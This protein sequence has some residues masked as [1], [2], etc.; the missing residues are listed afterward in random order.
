[1]TATK[2]IYCIGDSHINFFSGKNQIQASWPSPS[3]SYFPFFVPFRVGPVLAYSL[4]QLNTTNQGREKVFRILKSIPANSYVLFSFG[5][6]DCRNHLIKQAKV[7]KK[8]INSLVVNCVDRYLDMLNEVKALG[9]KILVWNVLP[10]CR[11]ISSENSP[12]PT[13][14]TQADRDRAIYLFN[15]ELKKGCKRRNFKF[16]SIY[17]K[18]TTSQKKAKKSYY[19]DEIHLSQKAM[20][21]TLNRLTSMIPDIDFSKRKSRSRKRLDTW[22]FKIKLWVYSLKM[23]FYVKFFGVKE[24]WWKFFLI[25]IGLSRFFW[26]HEAIGKVKEWRKN[27][28]PL[29]APAYFNQMLVREYQKKYECEVL[30]ET[31][32]FEGSMIMAV[33]ELFEKVYTIE[34]SDYYYKKSKNRLSVWKHVEVIKGDSARVLPKILTK[35]KGKKLLFWLDGHFSGG[36]T[37]KAKKDSPVVEELKVIA[38]MASRNCVVLVDD[39]REFT[40]KNGYP[41]LERLKKFLK[42]S[43]ENHRIT[44]E[45][46]VIRVTPKL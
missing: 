40:G 24:Y 14:G 10:L 41:K 34:L 17:D 5:E 45:D 23:F 11:Q 32:T 39:A 30:V 38:R 28:S 7:Q 18:V 33:A 21:L 42:G 2:K 19:F 6:I 36:K 8:T 43:L 26:W 4:S 16:V 12:Y 37:A 35:T 3:L 1:M 27:G 15:R 25:R 46:D 22:I 20:P 44:V 31:G 29:P 9:F 13:F